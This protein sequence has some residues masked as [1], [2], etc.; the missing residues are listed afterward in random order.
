MALV[1][2]W[3]LSAEGVSMSI[4]PPKLLLNSDFKQSMYIYIYIYI[5]TV[6]TNLF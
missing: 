2:H 5:Y 3:K 6:T 1:L 4:G